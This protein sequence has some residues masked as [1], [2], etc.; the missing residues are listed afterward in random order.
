MSK[1]LINNNAGKQIAFT[2]EIGNRINISNPSGKLLGFYDKNTDK[3]Y[4]SSG[5]QIAQGN[6]L[7][8]LLS[9]IEFD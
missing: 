4:T 7:G 1:N 6:Q 5:K 3:T 2:E 9:H 8:T